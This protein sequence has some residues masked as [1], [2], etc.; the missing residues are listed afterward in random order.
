MKLPWGILKNEE[1]RVFFEDIKTQDNEAAILAYWI[2]K[3]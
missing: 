3:S 2:A 1:F